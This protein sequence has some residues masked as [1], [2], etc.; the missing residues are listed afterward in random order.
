MLHRLKGR[1]TAYIIAAILGVAGIGGLSSAV[2]Q[3]GQGQGQTTQGQ[4]AQGQGQGQGQTPQGQGQGSKG[5][6]QL[7]PSD[8]SQGQGQ[9]CSDC[10]Q[11]QGQ[12]C[13]PDTAAQEEGNNVGERVVVQSEAPEAVS[14]ENVHFGG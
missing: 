2:A 9:N 12:G 1:P 8:C 14:T 10:A 11:G 4:T 5:Q 13:S 6:G 7:F 3:Q